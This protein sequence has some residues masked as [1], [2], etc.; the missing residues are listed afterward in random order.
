MLQDC[1]WWLA[2]A[3]G[4][5][6]QELFAFS[7]SAV[8][9]VDPENV[10]IV[11]PPNA[12]QESP[13]FDPAVIE[14]V[15]VALPPIA[16]AGVPVVAPAPAVVPPSPAPAVAV[17]PAPVPAP[18][19]MPAPTPDPAEPPASTNVPVPGLAPVANP[20]A[21]PPSTLPVPP[22]ALP[23]ETMRDIEA[24]A[25][26]SLAKAVASAGLLSAAVSAI[27]LCV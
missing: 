5:K 13:A 21:S 15:P 2:G 9:S 20:F 24:P 17:V 3:N 27:I 23:Q 19:P 18:A 16:P 1:C 14:I 7:P 26:S 12:V 11:P 10:V 8:P 22:E 4:R 6:L 25:P